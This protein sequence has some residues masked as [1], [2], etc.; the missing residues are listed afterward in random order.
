MLADRTGPVLSSSGAYLLARDWRECD[1]FHTLLVPGGNGA[2]DIRK[3]QDL[4]PFIQQAARRNRRIASVCSGAM[5]LAEAG[6]LDGRRAATHWVDALSLSQ[7]FPKV[8]VD[9]ESLYVGKG[10]I[11][12]SAGVV[13]GIDLALA[14]IEV[15]YGSE[16]ARRVAQLLVVPFRRAGT[17]AQHSGLLSNIAPS[18]RFGD[19]LAWARLNLTQQL[20][21]EKLAEK[22][23]LS[24][25]QFSR[26]FMSSIGMSPAK[27]IEKLRVESA[28]PAIEN[29][30]K[31]LEQIAR[32]C[33]FGG[34]DQMT[35]AFRRLLGETPQAL[36]RRAKEIR[37]A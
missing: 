27:A 26:A 12:T 17:Q 19:L 9:A 11:W 16:I 37:K 6:L 18:D 10:N 8:D 24:V 32:E 7:K 25:R 22:A 33:G 29:G 31:S 3:F 20:D 1:D 5:L 21:V 4:I 28:R 23:R 15:D 14:L 2:H 36:R 13:S 34:P 35:R 30:V